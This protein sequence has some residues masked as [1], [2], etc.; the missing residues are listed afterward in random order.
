MTYLRLSKRQNLAGSVP[1]A[2]TRLTMCC[3]LERHRPKSVRTQDE[4][5]FSVNEMV[6]TY[7]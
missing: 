5:S 7:L 6:E 2:V 1:T 4:F 3:D